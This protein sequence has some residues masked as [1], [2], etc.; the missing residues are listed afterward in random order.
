MSGNGGLFARVLVGIVLLG[1]LAGCAHEAARPLPPAQTLA[2]YEAR[3]IDD[4][5]LAERVVA[6]FPRFGPGWPPPR[7][8]RAQLLAVA[9][10]QNPHLAVDRAELAAATTRAA[11]TGLREPVGLTGEIEYARRER[12][13]WLYGLGLEIAIGDGERRRLDRAAADQEVLAARARFE[14]R[15]WRVRDELVRALS[16]RIAAMAA[17]DLG[18]RRLDLQ[19]ART[20]LAQQRVAAGEDG[21]LD[22][23]PA[24][25]ALREA[26]ADA[27]DAHAEALRAIDAL[28]A[29]LGLPRAAIAGIELDWDDWGMPPALVE[30][31]V[32]RARELALLSR[33][34]LAEA[35]AGHDA[36]ELALQREVARQ[37]PGLVLAP[38]YAWDHGIVKLPLGLGMTLPRLD[39]NRAAIDAALATREVAAARLMATQASVLAAI[40]GARVAERL[41]WTQSRAATQRVDDARRH[42]VRQARALHLGAIDRGEAL[43][44]DLLVIEAERDAL[45]RRGQHEDARRDLEDALHAPLSGPELTLPR[46]ATVDGGPT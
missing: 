36:S 28:A 14:G 22:A 17:S 1:L 7:W 26:E 37:R 19:R 40:D 15:A 8:N 41:A 21:S 38:G 10:A 30:D 45:R 43:A 46:N 13:P 24:R 33:S 29:A 44:A 39:G 34:D 27:D 16:A 35:I 42:A 11:A 2:A 3:R 18:A 12:S 25:E 5:G 23:L 6:R 9:L 20:A 32:V 31:D 4:A